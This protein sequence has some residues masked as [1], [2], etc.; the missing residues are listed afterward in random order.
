MSK[1]NSQRFRVS[2]IAGMTFLVT[3]WRYKGLALKNIS[4]AMGVNTTFEVIFF[5][6]DSPVS[7]EH[8]EY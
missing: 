6:E 5:D 2:K 7:E 8:F 3:E 4:D 1:K